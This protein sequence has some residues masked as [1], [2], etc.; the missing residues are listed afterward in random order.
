MCLLSDLQAFY[1]P[2][3]WTVCHSLFYLLSEFLPASLKQAISSIFVDFTL[4]AWQL[5]QYW[6]VLNPPS[7][8]LNSPDVFPLFGKPIFSACP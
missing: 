1:K 3:K 4:I 5:D 6:E 2:G 7:E 8:R